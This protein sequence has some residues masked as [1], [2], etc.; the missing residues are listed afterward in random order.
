MWKLWSANAPLG[1]R[2]AAEDAMLPEP[3]QAG[4]F[5]GTVTALSIAKR[6]AIVRSCRG[7]VG[8][9]SAKACLS[10]G[11]FGIHFNGYSDMI[12]S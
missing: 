10:N 4:H 5:D 7:R 6:A 2:Y 1:E 3:L 8:W 12:H 9:V 11:A